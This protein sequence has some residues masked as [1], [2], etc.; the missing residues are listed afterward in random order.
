[1]LGAY[2]RWGEGGVEHLLGA[3]A[4]AIWDGRE[5]RLV[6]A[7]DPIGVR[8]LY[9]AHRPGRLLAFASEPKALFAVPASSPRSTRPESPSP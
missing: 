6:C 4:F 5:R 2:A 3:F 7:R 8:P 9:L 1:M